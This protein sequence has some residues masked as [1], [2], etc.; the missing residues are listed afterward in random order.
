MK[1]EDKNYIK[2]IGELVRQEYNNN[3]K[4]FSIAYNNRFKQ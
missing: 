4:A 3:L 1:Q 2:F